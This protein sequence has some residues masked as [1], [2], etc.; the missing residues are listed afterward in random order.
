MTSS[1]RWIAIWLVAI[2]ISFIIVIGGAKEVSAVGQTYYV[3]TSGNDANPGTQA[4]PFRTIQKA[5]N[6][7]VAGD[8]VIVNAGTYNE[9]VSAGSS[10]TG[11]SNMINLL[12]NGSVIVRGFYVI[13]SSFKDLLLPPLIVVVGMARSMSAAA[14]MISKTL[15]LSIVLGKVS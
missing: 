11:T 8:T 7:A 15:Q 14:T 2:A 5:T 6:T 12:A 4:A 9:V 1:Q 3:S 13:T 10:G